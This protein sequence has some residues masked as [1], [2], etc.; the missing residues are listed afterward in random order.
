MNSTQYMMKNVIQGTLMLPQKSVLPISI[1]VYTSARS[2]SRN[3]V[4]LVYSSENV[5]TVESVAAVDD[6]LLILTS[7]LHCVDVARSGR[8]IK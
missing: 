4:Q 2:N 7:T 1:F 8:L 6:R 3:P 5:L